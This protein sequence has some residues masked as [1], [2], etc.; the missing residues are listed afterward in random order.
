VGSGSHCHRGERGPEG[1]PYGRTTDH[2]AGPSG[3]GRGAPN[4]GGRGAPDQNGPPW[5]HRLPDF[6]PVAALRS[7]RDP[8]WL[9]IT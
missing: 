2:E 9:R 8:R 7:G 5:W 6:V 1:P 3:S 4:E